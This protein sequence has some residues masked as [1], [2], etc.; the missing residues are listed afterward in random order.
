LY[1]PMAHDASPLN[2]AKA[3]AKLLDA[4]AIRRA[5]VRIAHEII[6]CNK[7]TERLALVGVRTRGAVLA[8]RLAKAIACR[9]GRWTSR[10]TGTT[11]RA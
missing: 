11:S 6:E 10:S 2:A 1:P 3:K 5:V 7:G 8:Q 4:D 9:L